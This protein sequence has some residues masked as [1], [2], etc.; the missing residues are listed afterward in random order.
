MHWSLHHQVATLQTHGWNWSF[1]LSRPTLGVSVSNENH[2]LAGQLLQVFPSPAHALVIDDAFIRDSDLMVRYGQSASD[3]FAFQLD[4]RSVPSAALGPFDCGL[5]LWLSV[6]TQLLD[7]H[8]LLDVRSCTAGG[9][10]TASDVNGEAG[11]SGSVATLSSTTNTGHVA[12]L[13]HP[14]DRV[15]TELMRLDTAECCDLRLFGSFM[16]KGVIRRARLRCLL[17]SAQIDAATLASAY[18]QF[19]DSPLPLT[20]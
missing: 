2:A 20:T 9:H 10:W 1:D 18:A 19:E 8:P 5:D 15:Q 7:S 11:A 13:V 14:S 12:L 6:Q 17:G 3:Q 16:E 4:F